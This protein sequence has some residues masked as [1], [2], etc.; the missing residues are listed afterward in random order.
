MVKN[1]ERQR[2]ELGRRLVKWL[3]NRL[4]DLNKKV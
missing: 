4:A 2:K 3:T 1:Q